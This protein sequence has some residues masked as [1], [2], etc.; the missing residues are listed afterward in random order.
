[1][2]ASTEPSRRESRFIRAIKTLLWFYV[3]TLK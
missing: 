1:M 3:L 2:T